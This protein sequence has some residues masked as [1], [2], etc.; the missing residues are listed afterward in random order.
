M[1]VN[2]FKID[3]K[4]KYHSGSK[5]AGISVVL[6]RRKEVKEVSATVTNDNSR[7]IIL[8]TK[9]FIYLGMQLSGLFSVCMCCFRLERR[10]AFSQSKSAR[11]S[12]SDGT[13]FR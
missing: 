1:Y 11:E 2:F 4:Q 7:E 12:K 3:Q 13:E 5:Q 6:S 8:Y 10:F 9:N